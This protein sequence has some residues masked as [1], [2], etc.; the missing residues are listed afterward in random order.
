MASTHQKQPP[1]RVTSSV[2]L[3]VEAEAAL[4]VFTGLTFWPQAELSP[5]SANTRLRSLFIGRR[6][7]GRC[8]RVVKCRGTLQET[9]QG[10]SAGLR[11]VQV[12]AGR[13][14]PIVFEM[15][16]AQ[17]FRD[18]ILFS[19]PLAQIDQSAAVRA[20]R[21]MLGVEPPSR[22]FAGRAFDGS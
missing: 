20:K 15:F 2:A 1:P 12:F 16:G 14:I 6:I 19:E 22:L 10:S 7:F 4:D 5:A 9:E 3:V 17:R 18:A 11:P 21:A 8:R 13:Q